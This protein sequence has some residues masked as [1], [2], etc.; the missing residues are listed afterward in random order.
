MSPARGVIGS[1]LGF[2]FCQ[3]MKFCQHHDLIDRQSYV[4]QYLSLAILA[5]GLTTLLGTDNLLAAFA[6]ST[7][8]AWDG[9][10]NKQ[11][12]ESLRRQRNR[13]TNDIKRSLL[14]E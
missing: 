13:A 3:L 8:F 2:S 4:A 5:I 14:W 6:C 1:L 9:L 10:F 11:T 7:S 12:E